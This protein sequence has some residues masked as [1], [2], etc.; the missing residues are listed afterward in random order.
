MKELTPEI[1]QEAVS[2][3]QDLRSGELDDDALSSIVIR[4]RQLLPD[5]E[6]MDYTVNLV[7]ELRPEEVVTKAFQY[8][9]IQL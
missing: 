3:I 8:R 7:P 5:P 4:L 9:P 6:F 1:L 2:L